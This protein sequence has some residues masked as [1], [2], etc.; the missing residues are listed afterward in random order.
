M[1]GVWGRRGGSRLCRIRAH[2]YTRHRCMLSFC[3]WT[4]G[5]PTGT[6]AKSRPAPRPKGGRTRREGLQGNRRK[7]QRSGGGEGLQSG[8][9]CG[10]PLPPL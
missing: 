8:Q 10:P 5:T 6:G 1:Q 7:I 2:T 9:N 3:R 4:L